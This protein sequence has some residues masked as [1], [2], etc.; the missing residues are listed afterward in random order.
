[1]LIEMEK[2]VFVKTHVIR[3]HFQTIEQLIL[4]RQKLINSGVIPIENIQV[5]NN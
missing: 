3:V 1:M 5:P 2:Y 4:F